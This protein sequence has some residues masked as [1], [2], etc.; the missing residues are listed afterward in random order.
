VVYSRFTP[1]VQATTE[2]L[3][4]LGYRTFRVDGSTGAR[5]R[6]L[7]TKALARR[8]SKPVAISAQVQA[9]SQ[10]VELVGAAEVVY[11]GVP[12]GW[13]QYFQTS[14][15]V[16]GPNQKRPVR[17]TFIVCP[18]SVHNLQMQSLRRK[19]EWHSVLMR[20]PRRYL[21]RL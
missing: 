4:G 19:E 10:S 15:R 6:S 9:L 12:E 18:G 7:A 13:T 21:T 20:N 14:R 2:S 1:E 17:L 16:M 3:E 5:D 11:A 8:P